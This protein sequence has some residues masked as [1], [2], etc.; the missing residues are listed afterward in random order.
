MV[1]VSIAILIAGVA[2]LSSKPAPK[3][4]NTRSGRSGSTASQANPF[5]DPAA[6]YELDSPVKPSFSK[7]GEDVEA[8]IPPGVG[9]APP[10]ERKRAQ[11]IL[12][13]LFGGL[14]DAPA[15]AS[16]SSTVPRAG[17]S[18]SAAA[19][20]TTA[21]AGTAGAALGRDD[22][23]VFTTARGSQAGANEVELDEVDQL[24]YDDDGRSVRSV[25]TGKGGD[26]D[27]D[28]DDDFGDFEAA[29]GAKRVN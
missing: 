2:L 7:A 18:G 16:S 14:P 29:T 27:D 22:D 6:A 21:T 19:A 17:G 9:T 20:G 4:N 11:G 5:D 15:P 12:S 10:T 13:R 24:G 28:D 26:G 3:P 8:A 25:R 23:S 1:W